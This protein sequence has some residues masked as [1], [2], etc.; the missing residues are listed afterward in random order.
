[1]SDSKRRIKMLVQ[2]KKQRKKTK[3]RKQLSIFNRTMLKMYAQIV[4]K[5]GKEEGPLRSM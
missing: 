2:F 1:M 3:G 5:N 4:T